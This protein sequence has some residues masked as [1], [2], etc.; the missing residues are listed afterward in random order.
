MSKTTT[1]SAQLAE[2][3]YARIRRQGLSPGDVVGTERGLAADFGVAYGTMREAVGRL[4]GIGIVS[5]RPRKGLIVKCPAPSH[6][7][8][9]MLPFI[10]TNENDLAQLRDFRVAIEM[11]AL[12]WA[13]ERADEQILT[14]MEE[15]LEPFEQLQKAGRVREGHE[16]DIRFHSLLL[17]ASGIELLAGFHGV[18]SEYFTQLLRKCPSLACR[19]DSGHAQDHR[20]LLA[21][22]RARDRHRAAEILRTHLRWFQVPP[23]EEASS[24]N[25]DPNSP[26]VSE[27]V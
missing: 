7:F 12:D 13:V 14:Q 3:V 19:S 10:A 25:N 16:F 20:N 24:A 2:R 22:L 8:G 5:G 18:I 15:T 9:Q 23:R 17:Q 1:L 11:G 21:A 27:V 4:R 6:L 26:G